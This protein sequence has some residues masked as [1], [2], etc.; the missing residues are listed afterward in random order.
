[1]N[2]KNLQTFEQQTD[3]ELRISDI[4]Q[5]C[6][7]FAEWCVKEKFTYYFN[8][9]EWVWGHARRQ[10][11]YTSEELYDKWSNNVA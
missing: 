6:I 1:M 3:K 2:L 8:G 5:R 9:K 10:E 7:L 11:Y 4:K